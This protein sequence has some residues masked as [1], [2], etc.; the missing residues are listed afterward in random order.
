M[1]K[2]KHFNQR[3]FDAEVVNA[4]LPAVV[5][6]FATW[7]GPCKIIGPVLDELA[8]EYAGKAVFGK[9]DVDEAGDLAAKHQIRGVPTVMFFKGGK[10]ITQLVGAYPKEKYKEEIE[11]LLKA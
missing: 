6:F 9:V 8:G 10:K 7:C 1:S 11:K 2:L 5:D 3:N 4:A